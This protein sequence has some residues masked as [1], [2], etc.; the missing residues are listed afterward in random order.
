MIIFLYALFLI[1]N[2]FSFTQGGKLNS[3]ILSEAKYLA[4]LKTLRFA[5]SDSESDKS[6]IGNSQSNKKPLLILSCFHSLVIPAK[7][8][9]QSHLFSYLKAKGE[10]ANAI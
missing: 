2:F 10:I 8:G 9:I 5:Q 1:S 3:V 4:F 7:A 6:D